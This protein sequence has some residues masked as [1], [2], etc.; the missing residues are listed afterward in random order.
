MYTDGLLKGRKIL[1]TGGGTGLGKAMAT[2]FLGLGA[3]VHICGRRKSVCDE[4]AAELM[5][6]HGG[7]VTSHGVDIRDAAAVDA[8]IETIFADGPLTDLINDTSLDIWSRALD[9][10]GMRAYVLEAAE[11]FDAHVAAL[12]D[13]LVGAAQAAGLPRT[14]DRSTALRTTGVYQVSL[15]TSTSLCVS[16]GWARIA[17]SKAATRPRW[18][19]RGWRSPTMR[20]KGPGIWW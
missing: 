14:L 9:V 18:F 3:E 15:P 20:T 2:R 13:A 11:A 10:A 19:F 17:S 7:K 6:A 1:I 12:P 16:C 4:T 5:K 8:M